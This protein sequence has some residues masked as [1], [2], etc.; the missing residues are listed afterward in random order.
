M[1]KAVIFDLDGTLANTIYDLHT[2]MN[3]MLE[4]LGYKKRSIAELTK[5]INNGMREFV[6]RSLP[7][8]VQNVDFILESAVQIYAE[9]YEKCYCEKTVAYAGIE[10]MLMELKSRG[11]KIGVLS[12]KQDSFVKEI[13]YKLFDKK[14]FSEV[15]GQSNLPAKPNPSSLLALCKT[16][17]VKPNK[18]VYVG[19]SDV[20]VET[21]I[22][23]GTKL[24]A[25]NWGYRKEDVLREAGALYV[26]STPNDVVELVK[27][28]STY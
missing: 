20:D 22:N 1:I 25:V 14:I 27:E 3:S 15:W 13:I 21:S 12:N 28:L 10:A 5:F 18:C 26:A 23:A 16:M 11:Y 17:G 7:R 9:E 6:R 4:R 24:I 8:D 19:D 2:A